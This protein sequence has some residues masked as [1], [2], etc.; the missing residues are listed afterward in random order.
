MRGGT[1]IDDATL[2]VKVGAEQTLQLIGLNDGDRQN[3]ELSDGGLKV[4]I[5]DDAVAFS[6]HVENVGVI[7]KSSD[8]ALVIDIDSSN[9]LSLNLHVIHENSVVV[10]EVANRFTKLNLFGSG[11]TYLNIIPQ[12]ITTFDASTSDADLFFNLVENKTAV[13]TGSG[14]EE[15]VVTGGRNSIKTEMGSD[16]VTIDGGYHVVNTGPDNDII[17]VAAGVNRIN[18][19]SGSDNISIKNGNNTVKAGDDNDTITISSGTN[20]VEGGGGDDTFTLTGGINFIESGDGNDTI[21]ASGGGSNVDIRSLDGGNGNDQ[22]N[23][24]STGNVTLPTA[25]NIEQFFISDTIHQSLDFSFSTS[26]NGIEL[27]SGTTID[28]S[29]ITLTLGMGQSL[30]LDS[31]TDGDTAAASL[32]DG[33]IVIAQTASLSTLDLTL[34]DVGPAISI[35][36]ENVFIDIAGTSVTT[37]QVTSAN[38][39]FVVLENSGSALTRLNITGVGVLGIMGTLPDSIT[40]I[41]GSSSTANLT[42][43]SGTGNDTITGGSGNDNITLT[44][45]TNNVTGGDGDDTI[46]LLAGTNTVATGLGDDNVTASTG[47]NNITTGDND[48]QVTINGGTN[49]VNTGAHDDQV[50]ISGGTNTVSS[51]NG[52]DTLLL[53]AG[54]NHITSGDGD[55]TITASGGASNVDI[56]TL[57]GGAGT[58]RL[59]IISTGTVSLPTATNIESFFISDTVHQSLD[60]SFSAS[61]N[62]IELDSGTTIDNSTITLTLGAGQALT[63]DSLTDG[64]TSVASLSDG[65]IIIA[66]AGSLTSLDL[67]L[68]DVGPSTSIANENVFIDIAGTGVTTAKVTSGNDS[69]VVISNTGEI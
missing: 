6:M 31:I 2:E 14:D 47:T 55:D 54:I 48:D 57:D 56:R 21:T 45:G 38:D 67:T 29:T 39:S 32:A 69:F 5:T 20:T 51:G 36:N 53:T 19:Q 18:T 42:L 15:I 63:L 33:G 12:Q 9:L 58:D 35:V 68:D 26:L 13:T 43:T 24:F 10:G 46:H 16:H 64:D 27:D 60:F 28:N 44:G 41:N 49:T 62:G 8:E 3:T 7:N 22:L 61:L 4:R 30:T 11:T 34:D 40:T 17:R 66:Q 37:A 52:D 50:T 25:V 59:N 65:G 23:I 1:T